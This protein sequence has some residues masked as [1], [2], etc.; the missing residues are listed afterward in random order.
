MKK[1]FLAMLVVVPLLVVGLFILAVAVDPR[2]LMLP[3]W[4]AGKGW[5]DECKRHPVS[6]YVSDQ[7]FPCKGSPLTAANVNKPVEGRG[8]CPL[9]W[10][11]MYGNLAATRELMQKGATQAACGHTTKQLLIPFLERGCGADAA[12]LLA[13][14]E[15]AGMVP[16]RADADEYLFRAVENECLV[17]VKFALRAGASVS[18]RDFRGLTPLSHAVSSTSDANIDSV[19]VL[20]A[21]G[22]D[23]H[24]LD[25][26][27]TLYQKA[28]RVLGSARNWPRMK[29]A[30]LGQTD[31]SG[32]RDA[33]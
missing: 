32:E 22:A 19:R 20:V 15:S 31:D 24:V 1:L 12:Q 11:A 3:F 26:S 8:Y 25:G 28:E 18:A 10:A 23:A 4:V 29:A 14:Y 27:E 17:G 6:A 33:R 21:A 5:E 16:D 13:L 2:A 7:Y 30:L 9:E